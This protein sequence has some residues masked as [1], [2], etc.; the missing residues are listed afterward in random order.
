MRLSKL[1]G[2]TL[3]EAPAEAEL[4]SHQLS[5]RAGLIR[6]L[7]AGI[8]SYLPLGWRVLRKIERI[9]REEMDAIGGQE[10]HMP[11]VNPAEIWRATGR[12]D[13][14]APGPAL[15]RF[16]DRTN[17]DLVLAMT[18]EEVVADL[19]R[20]EITSY[21]QL[22]FMI[23][24]I[25]TKFRDEARAR[26]GLI[27]TREFT[28]KDAYSC[29]PDF[30]SLDEFYPQMYQAYVNI[31]RRCGIRALPVIADSGVMGGAMSHEFIVPCDAGEDTL[32]LCSHCGYAANAEKATFAKPAGIAEEER[33]PQKIAT[34]GCIT[35][36]D[37]ATFVGVPTHQTLKALFYTTECGEIV[38]ALIRGDLEANLV[39]LANALGGAEL[40]PSTEAELRAAG[41][42]PG[43]ASPVSLSGFR[44]IAD[45]SITMGSNFVAGANKE[46][47]HLKN[48]NYPRDFTVTMI[49]DIAMARPGDHCLQCNHPLQT[50]RGIEVGH[51]FKLG[52]RYSEALG[53]TYLD[54]NGK[55][56]PIVMG[57]YGIGTG[58]L[59]AAII[60][61]NHD[62]HGIIWPAS[63]APYQ[64]HLLS[65]GATQPEVHSAAEQLYQHL[66][67]M[68][69]EVL[70]DDREESAGVKFNDAD[71]IGIPWRITV[72]RKTL[73]QESVELKRRSESISR[74]VPLAEL[75]SLL[76]E[77]V[78]PTEALSK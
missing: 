67:E 69:Y 7:A 62:E 11:V 32:V 3:R 77:W 10:L 47:Y 33:P 34:P 26:G 75:D 46:G 78:S 14:P 5:L 17:H 15:V 72:S 22:P 41:I 56:R 50:M 37:V 16:R 65:L 58:R 66:L 43:Y 30:D 76:A 23:Y 74:L 45:D 6:P 13:A 2:R 61:E 68:G 35:I 24:H 55:E 44:V 9:M 59:M 25:Q 20:R 27:R 29:H 54:R 60:E 28:M 48:V 51:L 8:Y 21:R 70:Y 31:F 63:V 49:T 39:K 36:A 12:Y 71:L 4:I 52:T 18:H 64:L 19:L 57:S 73:A 53:A 1:F 42:V 38:M 40:R